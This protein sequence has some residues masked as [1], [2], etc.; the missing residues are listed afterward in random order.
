MVALSFSAAAKAEICRY[1]PHRHCCA[2]AE[3]FGILLFCNSFSRDGIKIITESREFAHGLPRLFKQAFDISFDTFPSLEAPGKLVFQIYDS[4]KIHAIMDAFGFAPKDTLAL[5]VNLPVLEEECCK[6]AFLKGAFLAGGSVTD[7]AKGYHMEVTT[8]HAAVAREV[9]VLIHEVIGFETKVAGR[10][11]AQ[12]L[13]LKQSEL[14]SDFLTYLG[15]PVASMGI[16]EARLE[17]ELNN[18]VNRRCN[19]DDAN[20]SKVV[21]AAQEQLVAI[22][23]LRHAGVLDKIPGKLK[24]AA[25]AREENPEASLSELAALMEPP[26]TKPAMNNRMK[27]LMQYAKEASK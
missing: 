26:I 4:E 2:L 3:C 27:K 18:K 20:T 6:A 19:C 16:M 23:T 13:Y 5:H 11:G 15:A 1:T 7:P 10:A 22:R 9:Y 25:L 8:T 12:V 14:I 21:E 17:K 24:E